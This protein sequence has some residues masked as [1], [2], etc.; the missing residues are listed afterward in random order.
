MSSL[1]SIHPPSQAVRGISFGQQYTREQQDQILRVLNN[2]SEK[3][4]RKLA[5]GPSSVMRIL[6]HR[7]ENSG[8]SSME[9][10]GAIDGIRAQGLA[11][12]C[13]AILYGRKLQEKRLPDRGSSIIPPLTRERM[14]DVSD[15]VAIDVSPP[16]LTWAHLT[17][18]NSVLALERIK[19]LD[20]KIRPH[21]YLYYN[22]VQQVL[23]QLPAASLYVVEQKQQRSGA[24]HKA[25][26]SS[27]I[28]LGQLTVQAML[29]ALLS[30]GKPLQPQASV[31]SIKSSAITNIFDLNIGNE[32][33]SGQE[34]LKGLV[35]RW[36]AD[37]PGEAEECLLQG[38]ARQ[39]GT[40]LRSA[41]AGQGLL[42]AYGILRE[43]RWIGKNDNLNVMALSNMCACI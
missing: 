38:D 33:I 21:L 9:H 35:G 28:A 3:E 25:G 7:E 11:K 8:F 30:H 13:E 41:S 40:L 10:V 36:N 18:E 26:G 20:D 12:I 14:E 29:V 4:L 2:S 27:E 24:H 43:G 23:S 34:T 39:Q 31:V 5:I 22:A 15:I 32:R 19:F 17:R 16:Y 37:F 42:H 6:H 1:Q